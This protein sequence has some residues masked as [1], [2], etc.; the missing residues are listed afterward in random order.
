[1]LCI[2]GIG[3]LTGLPVFLAPSL[4]QGWDGRAVQAAGALPVLQQVSQKTL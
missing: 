2:Q 3:A 4:G 1:V